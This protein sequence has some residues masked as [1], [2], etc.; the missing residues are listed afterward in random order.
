[1]SNNKNNLLGFAFAKITTEQFAILAE[2]VDINESFELQTQLRFGINVSDKVL[3][4][5]PKFRFEYK[6]KPFLILES[7]SQFKIKDETWESLT[8]KENATIV[9]PRNFIIHLILLSIGTARGILHAKTENS[10]FSP[11]VL[12]TINADKIIDG[13]VVLGLER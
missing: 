2:D 11:L 8:D 6:E 13:D 7:S 9:F 1:M 5:Y 3:A 4:I 12:P 10:V